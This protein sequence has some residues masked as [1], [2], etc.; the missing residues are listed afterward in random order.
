MRAGANASPAC[1]AHGAI[2]ENPPLPT[3]ALL[4]GCTPAEQAEQA[5]EIRAI[6]G[7]FRVKIKKAKNPLDRCNSYTIIGIVR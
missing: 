1:P 2:G 5:G 3:G 6:I 4:P 7:F